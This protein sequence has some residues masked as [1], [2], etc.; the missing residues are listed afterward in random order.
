MAGPKRPQD[1]LD[2]PDVKKNFHD[3]LRTPSRRRRTVEVNGEPA[4]SETAR[5]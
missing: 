4:I 1:R 2:L 3:S 5:W